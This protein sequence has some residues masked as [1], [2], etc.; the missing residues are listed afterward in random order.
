MITSVT[1]KK[2]AQCIFDLAR[3][4]LLLTF[5]V[6]LTVSC[7][8]KH[9]ELPSYEGISLENAMSQLGKISSIEAGLAIQYEKNEASLSG[10]AFLTVSRDNLNLRIYYLGFLAGELVED[11][12]TIRSKPQL[13]KNK[14][15]MLVE[16]LKNSIFWWNIEDYT[17]KDNEGQYILTNGFRQIVVN[18]KTL[19]PEEQTLEL[20]NGET[21]SISYESP[22]KYVR[23]KGQDDEA[24]DEGGSDAVSRPNNSQTFELW[25]PSHLK[26]QYKNQTVK[27]TVKSYSVAQ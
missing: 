6:L 1:T 15:I 21:L 22:V 10:D 19:L 26:M 25:F 20:D 14:S 2:S 18:K 9:V 5:L 13:D 7:A 11:H 27:I 8:A 23:E 4:L 17:V 12:G 16:G 3:R 24:K